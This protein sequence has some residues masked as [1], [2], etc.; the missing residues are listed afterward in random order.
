MAKIQTSCPRCRQ[1][2]LAEVQQLF[3]V[4]TDPTAKQRLMSRSTN[5]ARCQ[6][7]GYEGMMSTP[8]VYHDPS[9]ELLLTF[10]PPEMGLPVNEQEKQI[11]P[12]INQVVNALPAEKRKGYL[13][14]PQTMFTYQTLLDKILEA[15]GITKE[16]IDAQQKRV[17]LIQRLLTTPKAE[18][19]SAI[20]AQENTLVDGAFFAILST[21]IESATMQGDEKSAQLLNEI[22]MQ[23][24]KETEVGKTLLAQSEETQAALKT[25]Q[26]A[27]KNGLTREILLD[28]LIG[29][30]SDS[31]LTTIVSLARNGLDYQFFQLLSEKIEAEVEDKKQHLID[32]RDKLLNITREIDNE[33]KNRL[34]DGVK[35]LYT[36]LEEPNLEEAVKKHMPEM[37]EFFTQ[38]LQ[39]EFETAHQKGDMERIEKIQKVISIVE[40]E[41][42]PPPEIEL[43]QSLL[44]AK[45]DGARQKILEEKSDLVNDQLLTAI[46]AII[47]EGEA[48]KQSPELVDSLRAVYKL[49]L[50]FNMEKNLKK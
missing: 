42:A 6:A 34:A 12:L 23:L 19:R 21:I 11:G 15:D 14:Q 26:E 35:L 25:L 18:D 39:S 50:R 28:T 20:I 4:N 22:Q 32:L 43:I 27:S 17:G 47:T 36:I 48:R 10:F 46:N 30:T 29:L 8:I 33:L 1:P 24:L 49:A 44:E 9:K 16:M 38:A 5:V 31:S 7:C 13:F 40:K 37:D 3:D 41:S 45:E 2:I